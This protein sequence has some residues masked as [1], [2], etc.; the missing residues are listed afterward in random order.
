MQ[1]SIF[2]LLDRISMPKTFDSL[3]CG[4]FFRRAIDD[5]YCRLAQAIALN[6]FRHT[7]AQGSYVAVSGPDQT[8]P[9]VTGLRKTLG[10]Y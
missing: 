3:Y 8:T 10:T 5:D 6:R 1:L 7:Q 4:T 9:S 2:L